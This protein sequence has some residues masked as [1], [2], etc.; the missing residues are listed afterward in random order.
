[1]WMGTPTITAG[2]GI[3]YLFTRISFAR[4]LVFVSCRSWQ[5][6]SA[7]LSIHSNWENCENTRKYFFH[8]SFCFHL[9]KRWCAKQ[10]NCINEM[11]T[12]L[13]RSSSIECIKHTSNTKRTPNSIKLI[14]FS[15]FDVYHD[16]CFNLFLFFLFSFIHQL[17]TSLAEL[18]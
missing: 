8:V 18:F 12:F 16:F 5:S 10:R 13:I 15:S 9:D 14:H 3:N 1:M 11:H 2:N 6:I 7:F 4:S 17:L